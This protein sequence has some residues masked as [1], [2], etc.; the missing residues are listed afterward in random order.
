MKN[1]PIRTL[2]VDFLNYSYPI[3][4]IKPQKRFRGDIT[5]TGGIRTKGNFKR[6]IRIN[7]EIIFYISNADEKLRAMQALSKILCRVFWV[8]QDETIPVIKNHLHIN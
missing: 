8:S 7:S 2:M 1:E 4:R 6:T 3:I 5:Q